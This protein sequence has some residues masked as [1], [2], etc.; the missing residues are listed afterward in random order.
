MSFP[1]V[2]KSSDQILCV[3][4]KFPWLQVHEASKEAELLRKLPI[5]TK[6]SDPVLRVLQKFPWFQVHEA[7][8]EEELLKQSGSSGL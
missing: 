6:S 3:L 4:Q 8:E 7:S 5:V 2:I 1:I